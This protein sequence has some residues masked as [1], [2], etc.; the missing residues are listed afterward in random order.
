VTGTR[1][2]AP[3]DAIF[4]VEA[5]GKV[6]L[7]VDYGRV[8]L[9]G[10]TLEEAETLIQQHL[11]SYLKNPTVLVARYVPLT[12]EDLQRRIQQLEKDVRQL[13]TAVDVL[14]GKRRE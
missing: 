12:D 7:G 13:R 2:D 5:S 9:K 14:R 4:L 3:I 10:L 8:D 1:P 6:A 11:K